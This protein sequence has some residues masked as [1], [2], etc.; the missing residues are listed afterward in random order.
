[1]LH[2]WQ[3]FT[4]FLWY[5]ITCSAFFAEFLKYLLHPW[6][7][8]VWV[9]DL[10][11]YPFT[12]VPFF[13][14]AGLACSVSVS[15]CCGGSGV[16]SAGSLVPA[17]VAGWG[18]PGAQSLGRS[19]HSV[20]VCQ[21]W[22]S[23]APLFGDHTAQTRLKNAWNIYC[24]NVGDVPHACGWWVPPRW[25]RLRHT[26]STASLSPW[27]HRG[28]SCWYVLVA[29]LLSWNLLSR[30]DTDLCVTCYAS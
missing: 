7:S 4:L 3:R 1:M 6:Q 27:G 13:G 15:A 9:S 20:L 25:H 10:F 16:W 12:S 22:R 21:D 19:G 26:R 18:G 14:V 24:K 17:V 8:T 29:W 28:A 11:L 2:H 5:F 23:G 30:K